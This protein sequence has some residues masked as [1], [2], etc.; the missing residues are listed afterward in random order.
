MPREASRLQRTRKR[1]D[2]NLG[3]LETSEKKFGQLYDG[4]HLLNDSLHASS[5]PSKEGHPDNE[6]YHE[7][8]S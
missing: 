8:G 3:K 5:T 7:S 1:T 4:N 2:F 6:K